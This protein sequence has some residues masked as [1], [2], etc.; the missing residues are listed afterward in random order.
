MI[1][2]FILEWYDLVCCEFGEFF[3]DFYIDS[4]LW[5]LKGLEFVLDLLCFC[6]GESDNLDCLIMFMVRSVVLFLWW[7]KYL[8]FGDSVYWSKYK[9]C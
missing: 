3:D 1:V 2:M 4:V 6:V 8:I 7:V 9:F 5:V